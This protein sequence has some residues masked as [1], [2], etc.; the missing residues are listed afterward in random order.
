MQLTYDVKL[1]LDE[2]DGHKQDLRITQQQFELLFQYCTTLNWGNGTQLPFQL[3]SN[4]KRNSDG[5]YSV[6]LDEL[7]YLIENIL[8]C[9]RMDVLESFSHI[10]G[11]NVLYG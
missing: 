8:S 10:R 1:D 9:G 3:P 4:L 7:Y 2:T 11:N 6:A 5:S